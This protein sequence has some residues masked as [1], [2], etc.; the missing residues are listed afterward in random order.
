MYSKR[1]TATRRHRRNSKPFFLLVALAVVLC[2]VVGTTVAYLFDNTE[3]ITNTFTPVEV[4]TEITEDFKNNVKNDV[5]VTNT[6]DIDAYIRAAVVV[7]WQNDD[8]NVYPTAPVEGTDYTVSYPGNGWVKHTDGY[9]YY[10]SAVAPNAST[11]VLLTDCKPVESKTPDGYHLV[12]EILASA[13]QAE[14][15]D[16]VKEAWSVTISNGSVTAVT[17]VS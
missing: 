2:A 9:Y 14:P 4:T 10:T 7:T 6:G 17:A 13:I 16:A 15:A 5:K 1:K 11:G 3:P 8:G 12:V